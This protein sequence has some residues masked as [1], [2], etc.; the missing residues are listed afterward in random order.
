MLEA[1]T[2]EEAAKRRATSDLNDALQLVGSGIRSAHS[3]GY[4]RRKTQSESFS[5]GKDWWVF[6]ASIRPDEEE[7]GCVESLTG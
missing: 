3:V 7:L 2:S 1:E 6:C 5:Y 4:S